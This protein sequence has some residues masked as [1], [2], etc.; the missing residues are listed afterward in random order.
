VGV[1]A[2]PA[3]TRFNPQANS[4]KYYSRNFTLT[5]HTPPPPPSLPALAS[6]A[7]TTAPA[8]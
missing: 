2:S 6:P 8:L 3:Q 1:F 7:A 4:S 5:P